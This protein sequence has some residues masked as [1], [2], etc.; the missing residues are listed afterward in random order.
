MSKR[1]RVPLEDYARLI[2][3][4]DDKKI[5]VVELG[6][7]MGG[8][9]RVISLMG[10]LK[11]NPNTYQRLIEGGFSDETIPAW[12][13]R[14]EET[15]TLDDEGSRLL[16]PV[17]PTE[18]PGARDKKISINQSPQ[19]STIPLTSSAPTSWLS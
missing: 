3:Y 7:E 15:T 13:T 12:V 4:D 9:R 17:K 19:P 5:P 10:Q 6:K 16:T 11:K 14:G 2:A 8:Y 18:K 1:K